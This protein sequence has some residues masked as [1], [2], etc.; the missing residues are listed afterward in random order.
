MTYLKSWK[1]PYYQ[2]LVLANKDLHSIDLNQLR[3]LIM[4]YHENSVQITAERLGITPPA[5][6]YSLRRLREAFGDVLFVRT[7]TGLSPTARTH[8]IMKEL[9]QLVGNL[10]N[11]LHRSITFDPAEISCSLTLAVPDIIGDWLIPKLYHRLATEA[12]GVYLNSTFWVSDTL[13]RLESEEVQLGL[14]F[15][16]HLPKSLFKKDLHSLD[17]VIFCR[18]NHP[19]QRGE[20]KPDLA[21][22]SHYPFLSHELPSS[23]SN[24]TELEDVFKNNNLEITYAAKV[25]QL[26]AAM[27][28]IQQSDMLMVGS[29]QYLHNTPRVVYLA[30]P[31]ELHELRSTLK[32]YYHRRQEQNPFY[33]WLLDILCEEI[34]NHGIIT[35][36]QQLNSD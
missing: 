3:T 26:N 35:D 32:A 28:L 9:P 21:M 22:L 34:V 19:L 11:L 14:H 29:K 23:K 8:S 20:N 27:S 24:S 12:P 10:D 1:S 36:A 33:K 7:S 25:S 31:A 17:P 6:S 5:V 4:L 2:A 18:E 15:I 16:D 13:K 30:A